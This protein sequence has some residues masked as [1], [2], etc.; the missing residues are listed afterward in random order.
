MKQ[1]EYF[2][3]LQKTSHL[4]SS[5]DMTQVWLGPGGEISKGTH[6]GLVR[7]YS[8]VVWQFSSPKMPPVQ[9]VEPGLGFT[10][11]HS[12]L[13]GQKQLGLPLDISLSDTG[14]RWGCATGSIQFYASCQ[15]LVWDLLACCQVWVPRTLWLWA[16]LG[17]RPLSGSCAEARLRVLVYSSHSLL[18]SSIQCMKIHLR[19]ALFCL[20]LY[21]ICSKARFF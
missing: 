3:Q 10:Q 18:C 20:C 19:R 13:G 1:K 11:Q 21:Y 15:A 8:R 17:P 14:A 4:L 9:C 6:L 5:V 7:G 12:Y 16:L 2:A